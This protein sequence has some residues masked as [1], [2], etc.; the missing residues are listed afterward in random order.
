V[1]RRVEFIEIRDLTSQD[2]AFFH[3]VNGLPRIGNIEGGADSRNASSNDQ[4]RKRVTPFHLLLFFL[5][6]HDTIGSPQF[7]DPFYKPGLEI[8]FTMPLSRLIFKAHRNSFIRGQ[9]P[10]YLFVIH[11]NGFGIRRASP[12]TDITARAQI[13]KNNGIDFIFKRDGVIPAGIITDIAFALAGPG[14][15]CSAV[16]HGVADFDIVS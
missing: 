14:E 8:F 2:E 3:Q 5:F 12:L 7:F 16:D 11:D 4:C 9:K 15:A 10:F 1:I 6:L 13:I